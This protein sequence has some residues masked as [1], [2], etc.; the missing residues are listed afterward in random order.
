[1][2]ERV[3][4]GTLAAGANVTEARLVEEFGVS[5]PTARSAIAR[6]VTLG[7][8]AQEP[9]KAALVPIVT[10]AAV[11][12]MFR[13]WIPLELEA[14]RMLS[15]HEVLLD[16]AARCAASRLADL[17]AAPLHVFSEEDLRFHRELMTSTGSE[18]LRYHWSLLE[19]ELQLA[20]LQ[21]RRETQADQVSA[22][23]LAIV[24]AIENGDSERAH[25]LALDHLTD[26]REEIAFR[27]SV[28]A[29]RVPR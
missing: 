4:D 12:D 2:H 9:N 17:G 16:P 28:G 23:H 1:M 22:E 14:I 18:R 19:K 3:A 29:W 13:V 7:L 21:A 8:L 5:R 24:A 10:G 11:R 26:S 27:V 6:A 25:R 15:A 20:M